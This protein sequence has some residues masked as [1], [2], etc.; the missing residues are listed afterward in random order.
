MKIEDFRTEACRLAKRLADERGGKPTDYMK[1][2]WETIKQSKEYK[3]H[4]SKKSSNGDREQ[5][6]E[7]VREISESI[8]ERGKE[9]LDIWGMAFKAVGKLTLK[10]AKAG[11]KKTGEHMNFMKAP[12]DS[13]G[14]VFSGLT[15]ML[16]KEPDKIEIPDSVKS[17]FKNT[18]RLK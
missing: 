13:P 6:R 15:K 3:N 1:E 5:R 7:R 17:L 12:K 8:K 9:S 10:G 16:T 4:Q 11:V 14:E 18:I 2:A